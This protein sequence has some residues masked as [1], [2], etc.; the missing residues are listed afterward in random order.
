MSIAAIKSVFGLP[1]AS[2]TTAERLL[3]LVMADEASDEGELTAYR[4]SQAHFSRKCGFASPDYVRRLV[5]ALVKKGLLKSSAGHGRT[6]SDYCLTF[7]ADTP[8][9]HPFVGDS[10]PP[11]PIQLDGSDPHNC[12]GPSSPSLPVTENTLARDAS[13]SSFERWWSVYP[14]KV[15]KPSAGRAYRA[16]LKKCSAQEIEAGLASWMPALRSMDPQFVPHPAT[17]LNQER[18]ND[19]PP[20]PRSANGRPVSSVAVGARRLRPDDPLP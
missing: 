7:V 16:A 12:G 13:S 14:K 6:Q 1:S 5:G 11:G 4:R 8:R 10:I 9:S 17:W 19:E 15:A 2:T 3:L 20:P 18:W